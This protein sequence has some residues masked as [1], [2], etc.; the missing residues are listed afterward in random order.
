MHSIA[1]L[2]VRGEKKE[3]FE[4]WFAKVVRCDYEAEGVSEQLAGDNPS[5]GSVSNEQKLT[6]NW[7]FDPKDPRGKLPKNTD[8]W[9]ELTMLKA[10]LN[11]RVYVL[12]LAE[13]SIPRV[14]VKRKQSLANPI[15][16]SDRFTDLVTP[17]NISGLCQATAHEH[18]TQ[19]LY[20]WI[21]DE[22]DLSVV[23][24][25]FRSYLVKC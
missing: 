22:R 11:H 25:P 5:S 3:I 17:V 16:R 18:D 23:S 24:V 8:R 2:G 9:Q 6:V 1:V 20:R 10:A 15:V 12:G 4:T 7:F 13:D 21:Y 14:A 19:L